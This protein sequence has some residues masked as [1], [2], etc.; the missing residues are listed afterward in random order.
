[1][2]LYTRFLNLLPK[3]KFPD[4]VVGNGGD[5][6]V[7]HNKPIQFSDKTAG[8]RMVYDDGKITLPKEWFPLLPQEYVVATT[9][10]TYTMTKME[11]IRAILS[12]GL[13]YFFHIRKRKFL[14]YYSNQ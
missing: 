14:R 11:W 5:S 8:V 6:E 4:I 9:G 10:Q 7:L 1:M 12:L 2:N 13:Y 3:T